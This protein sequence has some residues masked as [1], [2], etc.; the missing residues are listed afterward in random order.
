MRVG[1]LMAWSSVGF[2]LVVLPPA[3][4]A[5]VEDGCGDLVPTHMGT[6]GDDELV[7]TPGDDVIVA[8]AGDD[9]L[10]G[11]G[12]NDVLCGGEGTDRLVG[13][14]GDDDLYGG[15]NGLQQR[16]EDN[17]PDNVGDTLVPGAG[18]DHLDAGHDTDTDAGGGFRP[19]RVV[20]AGSPVGV[21]VD[22]TAGSAVGEGVDTVVVEGRLEIVGSPHDDVLLGSEHSD[23]LSG[24]GGADVLRGL[25]GDD[26]LRA[27]PQTYRR[28]RPGWA[29]EAYGGAGDDFLDLGNGDDRGR[30]GAGRDSL[31]HLSGPT[32]LRGGSGNDYL[33]SHLAL[34]GGQQLVGGSGRDT[35]YVWSVL[36]PAGEVV[37]ARG[38]IDLAERFIR[39]V[40]ADEVR[41]ST[42]G[43]VEVLRVPDGV[44]RVLGTG[45]DERIHGAETGWSRV[46]VH[47]G[48]GDDRISGTPGD[49]RIDGGPG[50]DRSG[51]DGGR[52]VC[53][54]IERWYGGQR[55]EVVR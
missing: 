35:L 26:A 33:E 25:G 5:G 29:D 31:V 1:R 27:D 12:G 21:T 23:E 10:T 38:R 45:R 20:F 13:G 19:D 55:C 32:D 53:T 51:D 39:V 4:A 50:T 28:D 17:P 7:G 36:G 24:G 3:T 48:A 15:A 34:V 6:A 8:L 47:A 30:G 9:I 42:L 43:G 16:Y 11:R 37:R 46:M 22:L 40:V 2:V 49:D 18:D 14:E 44:W 52:D 41:R 54:S